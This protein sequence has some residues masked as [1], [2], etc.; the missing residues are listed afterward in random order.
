MRRT[1]AA[2]HYAVR[3][4][5]SEKQN[6]VMQR[7]ADSIIGNRYRDFWSEVRKINGKSHALAN[8]VEGISDAQGI[9]N[10]FASKFQNLYNSVS[11]DRVKMDDIKRELSND[12]A[13]RGQEHIV[14]IYAEDVCDA[15]NKMKYNKNDG[16]N[17]LSTNHLKF[18]G[19]DLF[20]HLS[21]LLSSIITH[22]SLPNDFL[23]GTT[24]P[25]PKG[26]NANLTCA[27]NYRGITLGSIFG[28]VLDLMILFRYEDHLSTS[29][30]QFGF[31]R[32]RS[33]NMCTMLLKE[34]ISYYT[35]NNSSLYCVF[36]DATKAF[37]K[38]EYCSLFRELMNRDIP[39]LIVRV[40]LNIYTGQQIRVLWNG[41]YSNSFSVSRRHFESFVILC[42][43]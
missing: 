37:D 14:Q 1:R 27:D 18:A 30:L 10:M 42:V 15:V 39:P 6:I 16:S 40:L 12:I 25:I 34:V 9:A 23:Q 3:R 35:S 33:T 13:A 4:V 24:I 38:V 36:L 28:R 43:L 17:D 2:Y 22:G 20:W 19:Y 5:K 21:L 32:H 41:A 31:K 7:F 11:Y 26:R 29:D 8:V